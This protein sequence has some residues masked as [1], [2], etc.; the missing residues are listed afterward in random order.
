MR[1]SPRSLAER[2]EMRRVTGTGAT[3]R[4]DVVARRMIEEVV[5]DKMTPPAVVAGTAT[6]TATRTAMIAA[7]TAAMTGGTT[8]TAAI[9]GGTTGGGMMIGG[10]T[11]T[12]GGEETI[13]AGRKTTVGVAM[14]TAERSE[15]N[16][17]RSLERSLE[18]SHERSHER[19]LERSLKRR[20]M[21]MMSPKGNVPP[22]RMKDAR[23]RKSLKRT[24][25]RRATK[26]RRTRSAKMTA[27]KR[28]NLSAARMDEKRSGSARKSGPN[29]VPRRRKDGRKTK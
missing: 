20:A 27:R 14:T 16:L 8:G 18:R 3:E 2:I 1:R 6:V 19:S 24:E 25:R 10:A 4:S 17:V 15:R 21:T 5:A 28:E 23:K 22:V 11:M 29:S 26:R 12:E 13:D 9:G 7:T